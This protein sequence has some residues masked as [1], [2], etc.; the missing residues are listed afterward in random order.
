MFLTCRFSSY[1]LA[2][3][4]QHHSFHCPYTLDTMDM[5][6][7]P[8]LRSCRRYRNRSNHPKVASMSTRYT[9]TQLLA[10]ILGNH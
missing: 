2:N 6:L 5:S 7:P 10:E 3:L 1:S 8:P 9:N 4:A